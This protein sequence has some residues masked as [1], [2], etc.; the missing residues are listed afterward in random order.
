M[1]KLSTLLTTNIILEIRKGRMVVTKD[2]ELVVEAVV[3]IRVTLCTV[4]CVK[5]Q[6]TEPMTAQIANALVVVDTTFVHRTSAIVRDYLGNKLRILTYHCPMIFSERI[7]D[8]MSQD[9]A[10]QV[11]EVVAEEVVVEIDSLGG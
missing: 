2:V 8:Q 5:Q 7:Q 9:A 4:I 11:L 6:I 3:I 1:V 10:E